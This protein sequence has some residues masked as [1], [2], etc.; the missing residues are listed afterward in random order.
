LGGPGPTE[1]LTTLLAR[2]G[3][4][5]GSDRVGAP[6]LVNSY[7]PGAFAMAKFEPLADRS[8]ASGAQR[9]LNNV[10][11]RFRSPI[12]ARVTLEQGRPVRVVTDRRG[13]SGG[14]VERCD[15]PWRSSGDWWAP[16]APCPAAAA[17]H[18]GTHRSKPHAPWNC[19]EWDVMLG[20]GASYRISRCIAEGGPANDDCSHSTWFVDGMLD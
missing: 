17:P 1:R 5:M 14:K 13:F 2:L 8:S 11:R 18:H 7:R 3:A 10:I 9:A 12:P 16:S 15:G 6:A 19:D 20:D 4:L